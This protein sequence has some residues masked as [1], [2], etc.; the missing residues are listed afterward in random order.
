MDFMNSTF[1]STTPETYWE[2]YNDISGHSAH[3][4]VAERL[5]AAWYAWMQNDVLATGIMSFVMHELVYFGRSLPWILIDT[6][7]FF[8]N[9]KIQA[10]K[11]PSL[12]EQWDCAKFVL[13]S[14]FTVELPQIWLFHPMAQFFGLSTS[15][16]FPSLWTMA[17]QIAIFF[18]MEDTWHYFSHRAL[19][20][21]PLYKAIHK[22]HHQYSAPFGMAAEYASPIEVMILGFG[23]VGCPIVWCAVTGDLHIFTI[24][25]EFPWSLHHFLP[26]WAGAD[27]HDLHHEKFVGNYASSF[28]WWD[29][30]LDTEYSPE[31]IKRRREHK[32]VGGSKKA[33]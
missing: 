16:P 7:G 20:W 8:K 13:L 25:Y 3:F 18:V 21:G 33:Q 2:H 23:T 19:H 4:N 6:L 30:V 32:A 17:Y 31:A 28:R 11:I 5:W 12:R 15:V 22:I 24:G 10:A 1:P 26:F 29:Y 9:Y 27:H 14:H